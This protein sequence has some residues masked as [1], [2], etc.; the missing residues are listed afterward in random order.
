MVWYFLAG[1]IG[2]VVAVLLVL[3]WWAETHLHVI[4]VT[5]EEKDDKDSG[6][7]DSGSSSSES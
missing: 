3:R 6:D 7:E 2:G 5:E 4:D 1:W